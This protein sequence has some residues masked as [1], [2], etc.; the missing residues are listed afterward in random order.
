MKLLRAH[1]NEVGGPLIGDFADEDALR[2]Y[3][4]DAYDP[5]LVIVEPIEFNEDATSPVYENAGEAKPLA[6]LGKKK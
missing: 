2:S 5:A 6:E 1:L 3:V 4:G